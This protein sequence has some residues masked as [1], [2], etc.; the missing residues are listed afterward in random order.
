VAS[1][2]VRLHEHPRLRKRLG[3]VPYRFALVLEPSPNFQKNIFSKRIN[4]IHDFAG[5]SFGTH[6]V[7]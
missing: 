4:K 6:P 1:R 5:Q 3:H 2:A 7:K